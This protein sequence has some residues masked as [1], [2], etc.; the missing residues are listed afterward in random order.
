MIIW[1]GSSK[2]AA[3][4]TRSSRLLRSVG[5]A[6]RALHEV[7]RPSFSSR[8][9]GS[10]PAFPSWK[11]YIEYRL[12]QVR[13]R[14]L[15]T[16][17]LDPR[18]LDE[19]CDLATSVAAAVNNDAQ[20]VLC[21]RDLHPDNLIVNPEGALIG[22]IDWDS[23]E[24]WD[25]AGDWFKLEYEL[26]RVHPTG[27]DQLLDAYLDGRPAPRNWDQ[28]RRLIH[29]IETLNIL[30]NAVALSWD[31]EFS[32]RARCHMIDLLSDAA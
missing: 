1:F 24:A 7:E 3:G 6:V 29:L 22:I 13:A 9:D 23:A 11:G 14:C 21:H 19:V 15:A 27:R 16:E 2:V 8:L 10:S 4:T 5:K 18:L 30:S 20:A 17:A 25:R 32:D 26:L 31:A 12:E 28:R